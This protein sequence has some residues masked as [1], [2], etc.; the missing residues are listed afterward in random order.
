MS[1]NSGH[2][3]SLL[4]YP[5]IPF[6]G[7]SSLLMF[8]SCQSVSSWDSFRRRNNS[9][10]TPR[11]VWYD[12]ERI[13]RERKIDLTLE[14]ICRGSRFVLLYEIIIR[15][16]ANIASDILFGVSSHCSKLSTKGTMVRRRLEVKCIMVAGEAEARA[17]ISS[18]DESR[19]KISKMSSAGS[20]SSLED[21]ILKLGRWMS[22][23]EMYEG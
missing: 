10:N 19:S 12:K 9:Q 23:C 17:R 5:K 13:G 14:S 7:S 8:C 1:N 16:Q 2:S 3:S 18:G 11:L 22:R 20:F 6:L 15:R 21:S 4:L